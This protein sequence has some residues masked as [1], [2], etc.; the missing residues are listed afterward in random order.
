MGFYERI[1]REQAPKIAV[2]TVQALLGEIQR[3]RLTAQDAAAVLGLDVGEQAE[4]EALLARVIV[5]TEAVSFG[6]FLALTNIGT[7]YDGTDAARGL[8]TA[9]VQTAGITSVIFGVRVNKIGSGTQSWQLW[10]ETDGV[11][12]ALIDDAGAAGAKTLF[13]TRDFAQP[14]DAG[15]KVV[16]VR[17]KSTTAQDDPVYYGGAAAIQRAARLTAV[18][19]HEILLLA[20]IHGGPY[21]TAATLKARLGVS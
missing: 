10:N 13:V 16:R 17:A 14:L 1:T 5:P 7:A 4:A 3:G 9:L 15:L 18:E 2:H 8:G 6:G 20:E 19:L 11:E 21:A 12:I